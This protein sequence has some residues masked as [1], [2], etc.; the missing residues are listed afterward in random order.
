M[1]IRFANIEA[2]VKSIDFLTFNKRGNEELTANC[3]MLIEQ[4]NYTTTVLTTHEATRVAYRYYFTHAEESGGGVEG[5]KYLV[6]FEGFKKQLNNM[7][8]ASTNSITLQMIRGTLKLIADLSINE[9]VRRQKGNLSS[10]LYAGPITDFAPQPES[11]IQ[12]AELVR[13][14]FISFINML[15]EFGEFTGENIEGSAVGRTVMFSLDPSTQVIEGLTNNKTACGYIKLKCSGE[16]NRS[17]VKE[18]FRFSVEG[19]YLKCLAKIALGERVSLL[20]NEDRSWVTFIGDKGSL[21]LSIRE[22]N[23]SMIRDY[24]LFTDAPQLQIGS[25]RSCQLQELVSA[26]AMQNTTDGLRSDVALVEVPPH[27]IVVPGHDVTGSDKSYVCLDPSN[28]SGVFTPLL[29]STSGFNSLLKTLTTFFRRFSMFNNSITL[30]QKYIQRASGTKSWLLYIS[31]E[32]AEVKDLL[33][34][35]IVC[36]DLTLNLDLIDTND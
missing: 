30:T 26:V 3:C 4:K 27:I 12:Y 35:L 32:Q 6:E 15:C 14:E 33:S 20:F 11:T 21:T 23:S 34:S 28:A 2:L 22:D 24:V 36:N 1:T 16:I 25:I 18:P 8:A 19:R 7:K 13:T 9:G 5:A 31:F 10:K 29:I 17:F